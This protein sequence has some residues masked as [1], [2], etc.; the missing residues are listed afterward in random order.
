M[1]HY[2]TFPCVFHL[3]HVLYFK[4]LIYNSEHVTLLASSF[5]SDVQRTLLLD[6]LS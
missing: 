5:I 6:S 2:V 4:N 1:W 3:Q